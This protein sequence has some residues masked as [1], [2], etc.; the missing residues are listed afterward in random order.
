MGILIILITFS[1]IYR[2]KLQ[3]KRLKMAITMDERV[4]IVLLS[5]RLGWYMLLKSE[6]SSP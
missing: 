6:V 1:F 2:L 5:G 3:V 4:E